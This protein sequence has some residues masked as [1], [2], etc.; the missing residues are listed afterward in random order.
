MSAEKAKKKTQAKRTATAQGICVK[1][2]GIPPEGMQFRQEFDASLLDL[3]IEEIHVASPILLD[4]QVYKCT[5]T[6]T[7]EAHIETRAKMTCGRCLERYENTVA[8]DVRLNY[9]IDSQ[10]QMLDLTE[11]IRQEI[12]LQY[13]M[14]ALCTSAC[15]GLCAHCGENLNLGHCRCK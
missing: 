12:I 11:D 5:D 13:P 2:A 15:K 9:S 3:D 14:K 8:S 1:V 4:A 6:V 10:T 7:I